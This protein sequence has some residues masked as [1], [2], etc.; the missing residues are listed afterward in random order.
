M[1]I[2]VLRLKIVRKSCGN[3]AEIVCKSLSISTASVRK[4]CG[5]YIFSH[6][7]AAL[8]YVA[9]VKLL[10]LIVCF[11]IIKLYI[12]IIILLLAYILWKRI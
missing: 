1:K 2:L 8:Y 4:S 3:R 7:L 9:T 6:I 11:F 5:N 12:C 10:C